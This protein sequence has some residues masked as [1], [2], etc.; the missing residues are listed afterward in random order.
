[1]I[2][3]YK[4]LIRLPTFQERY[5]YLRLEGILGKSTFGF[6]RYI[7]Q[8]F[9]SSREWKQVR[10]EV[11]VRDNACDLA[12]PDRDLLTNIRVHHMNPITI[13]DF[14]NGSDIILEPEF[15]I[16]VSLDTHN[17]IHFGDASSLVMLPQER[18][19]GD[20]VPWR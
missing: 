18:R 9:Y 10:N 8:S 4:E 2:R 1:M 14:E 6:D 19:K 17:A 16:C 7:N 3:T 12:I 20:T 5:A 15:L 11:I 13:E